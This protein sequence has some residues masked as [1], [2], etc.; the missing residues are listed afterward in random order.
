MKKS[1]LFCKADT[2]LEMKTIGIIGGLSPESTVVYYKALNEGI[3][4]R[5]P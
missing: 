1:F 3:R 2:G 5:T 4:D